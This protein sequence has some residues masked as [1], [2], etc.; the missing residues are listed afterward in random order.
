[1][2]GV[3]LANWGPTQTCSFSRATSKVASDLLV[4]TDLD[5]FGV[6]RAGIDFGML[7]VPC[8]VTSLNFT[9]SFL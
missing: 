6:G 8:A 2:G 9:F 4:V 1:V 5:Q 3:K 7:Q